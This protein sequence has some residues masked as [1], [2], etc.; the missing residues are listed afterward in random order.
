MTAW[1]RGMAALYLGEWPAH[2]LAVDA[3]RLRAVVRFPGGTAPEGV[4]AEATVA[5]GRLVR[6]AGARLL[7][8]SPRFVGSSKVPWTGAELR[9]LRGDGSVPGRTARACEVAAYR[10]WGTKATGPRGLTCR[11]VARV[12]GCDDKRV[13]RLIADGALAATKSGVRC[14]ANEKWSVSEDALDAF[15]TRHPE[16]YD[17]R[18][19]E[20]GR[21]RD[22]VQALNEAD[23]LLGVEEAAARLCVVR[24]VVLRHI[25]RRWLPAVWSDGGKAG[26]A[27]RWLVRT[28]A[29]GSF[30]CK[31]ALS[32]WK[33][34][35]AHDLHRRGLL[36]VGEAARRLGCTPVAVHHRVKDGK[37]G[38]E[39]VRVGGRWALGVVLPAGE[40]GQEAAA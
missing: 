2:V 34:A 36:T 26:S 21:W 10:W 27:R 39:R 4:A 23:P 22:R 8:R 25:A 24:E 40:S 11:R 1:A 31:P 9:A 5:L 6:P 13:A 16:R 38:A 29:L 20:P 28:S 3:P 19:V 32:R 33:A 14:G 35:R 18:Q 17:W 30:L 7:D 37:L 15:L 12:L